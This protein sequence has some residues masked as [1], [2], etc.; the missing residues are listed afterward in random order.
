MEEE[1]QEET[2]PDLEIK[3]PEEN[4]EEELK[5]LETEGVV[6]KNHIQVEEPEPTQKDADAGFR[7]FVITSIIIIIILLIL[8]IFIK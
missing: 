3:E 7:K 4:K 1:K 8:L 5:K 2:T 6:E